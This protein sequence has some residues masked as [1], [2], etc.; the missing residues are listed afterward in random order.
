MRLHKLVLLTAFFAAG[1]FNKEGEVH[2]KVD[3]KTNQGDPVSDAHIAIDGKPIGKT[4]SQ[5]R[6]AADINLPVGSKP[7]L[8]VKKDSDAYYFAPYFESFAVVE[9]AQDIGVDATLYFVPKPSPDVST[10]DG[11]NIKGSAEAD[12][13]ST[14]L[15]SSH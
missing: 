15:N 10:P 1:C 12:R 8:E 5:G 7:K 9:G 3:V 13:K 6:F 11:G 4:D 14:R 2:V